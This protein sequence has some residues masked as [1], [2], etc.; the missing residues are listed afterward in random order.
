MPKVAWNQPM[1]TNHG[2]FIIGF[3][4]SKHHLAIA[5]ERVAINHFS[6][7]IIQAG[8]SYSKELMHT[9]WDRAFFVLYSYDS[10]QLVFL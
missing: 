9:P 4:I 1:F 5:P 7:E 6:D 10:N 8:H 3:S 2:T